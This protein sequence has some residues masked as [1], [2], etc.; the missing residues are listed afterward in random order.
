M[1]DETTRDTDAPE[2]P[3]ET[4]PEAPAGETPAAKPPVSPVVLT[5]GFIIVVLLGI[6]IFQN[7]FNRPGGG[8]KED[9]LAIQSLQA[10]I[11]TRQAQLNRERLALGLEP[12][13]GT[14]GVETTEEVAERLTEDAATLASLATSFQDLLNRKEMELDELRSESI[15]ALKEQKRLRELLNQTN[16]ELRAAMVDASMATTIKGELDRANA[17]ISALNE[18]I[19]RLQ[20]EPGELRAQLAE[21]TLRRNE[22]EARVA[23]LEEQLRKTNLFAASENELIKEAV[24]LFKALRKLEGSSEQELAAAYSRFGAEL[25]SEVLDTCE[26]ATGSS[27]VRADLESRLRLLPGEAP[28]NAM[29]F[30]V[31]YASETGNVDNNRTL[32]SDRATAV[33]RILDTIKRPGQRVQAV[34]LGQ[35]DRFSAETPV[36]NQ[37]V[38]VWQILPKAGTPDAGFSP[39][40]NPPPPA[41]SAPDPS[42]SD[43]GA[44]PLRPLPDLQ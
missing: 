12:L 34:Y 23:E 3:P 19:A 33:A 6:I 30:V 28:E 41:P 44:P 8:G 27:E 2:T 38:E 26:F 24:A 16:A 37:R 1:N 43:D 25:R 11:K 9:S 18:E 31:G 40:S 7:L 13:P 32:S 17:T 22:L 10:D 36:K 4:P 42:V 21:V 5:I 29:L 15:S 14:T 35:T 39:G 20:T